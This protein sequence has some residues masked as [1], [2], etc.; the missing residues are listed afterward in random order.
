MGNFVDFLVNKKT[1]D[2]LP[3]DIQDIFIQTGKEI[4]LK[5]AVQEVPK[6]TNKIM[7]HFETQ[8]VKIQKLSSDDRVKWANLVEDIPAEWAAEV[9]GQGYPGWEI[10]ERYQQICA[11][12]GYK[13]PR[14]WGIKK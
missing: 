9:T 5:A 13:W 12:L 1:F 11:E 7:K 6:W 8:N 2:R 10:V 3:K 14:K 4:E